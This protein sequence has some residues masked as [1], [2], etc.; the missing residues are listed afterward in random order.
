[1][2]YWLVITISGPNKTKQTFYLTFISFNAKI[3]HNMSEL[4]PHDKSIKQVNTSQIC[5]PYEMYL[6]GIAETR[7]I[8]VLLPHTVA[9]NSIVPSG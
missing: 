7:K 1:M 2:S 8:L 4:L 3:V 9:E 5:L 6:K